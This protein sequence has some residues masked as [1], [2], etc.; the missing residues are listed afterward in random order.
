MEEKTFDTFTKLVE[1]EKEFLWS[2]ALGMTKKK[3]DAE[4]LYQDTLLK[5]FRGWDGFDQDTNFRAWMGRIMLNT[6]INNINRRK[7]DGA[8]DLSGAEYDRALYKTAV[9]ET[10]FHRENPENAFF[11]KHI[12]RNLMGVFYSLQ[13][14]FRKP[15]ALYHFE[16]FQYEEIAEMLRL[17]VG[18]IKSRIFR[19]RKALRE[20][21]EKNRLDN[22]E[23]HRKAV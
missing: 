17:P 3:E 9:D 7:V 18:T 16:G 4:D 14:Q 21:V 11:H 1:R 22:M 8:Y 13:D 5:A 23:A 19:A 2:H 12:D 10:V 6:H 15:F 20:Q